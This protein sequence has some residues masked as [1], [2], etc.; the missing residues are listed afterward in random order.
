MSQVATA[1]MRDGNRR[2]LALGLLLIAL[3]VLIG[4]VAVPLIEFGRANASRARQAGETLARLE[5]TAARRPALDV[6]LAQLRQAAPIAG[7]FL[8]AGSEGQGS[9]ALQDLMKQTSGA[10]G[11][12]LVTMQALPSATEPGYRRVA[13][14]VLLTSDTPA[15]QK[16]LHALESARPVALVQNLY[17]RARSGQAAGPS[18]DRLLEINLE[19]VGFQ[20]MG[21]G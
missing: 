6:E 4:L 2:W 17:V 7:L 19:I 20:R 1:S 9:A 15:L 10:A 13:L 18:A 8:P 16:L 11:A 14:K 5:A 3:L 21:A 12:T